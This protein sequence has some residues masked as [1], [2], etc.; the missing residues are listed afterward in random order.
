MATITDVVSALVKRTNSGHL[1]WEA[2]HWHNGVPGGWAATSNGC[3]FSI[4]NNPV[5]LS[6]SSPERPGGLVQVGKGQQVQ[7]LLDIVAT[8]YGSKGT[9]VDEAIEMAYRCLA[10]G[11]QS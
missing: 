4:I 11:S 3:R 1:K 2:F 6:V 7:E 8:M 5:E 10:E 9:T